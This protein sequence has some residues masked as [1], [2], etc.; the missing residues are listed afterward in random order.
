MEE[1]VQFSGELVPCGRA[2]PI[3]LVGLLSMK[4]M[5]SNSDMWVHVIKGKYFRDKKYFG[6]SGLWEH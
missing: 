6:K 5:H 4:T 1:W 3:L 2:A